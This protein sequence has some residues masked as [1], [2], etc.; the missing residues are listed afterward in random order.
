MNMS[1]NEPQVYYEATVEVPRALSD[2]VCKFII[3][4]I[5]SGLVLE[6]EEDSPVTG[7]KFYVP[8]AADRDYRARL[9]DYLGHLTGEAMPSVPPIRERTIKNV[10]WTKEYRDSIEPV[11]VADDLVVRPPWAPVPEGTRYDIVIEPKMAF[12]TGRHETT[13]TCLRIVREKLKPGSRFLDLGCG[14]GILSVLADKMGAGFIK[15]VDHD[16]VAIE[17]AHENFRI[18]QVATPCQIMFGSVD[19]CRDDRPYD[20]I[21]ANIIKSTIVVMIEKLAYLLSG[22][23]IMI[24]SGLLEPDLPE[25]SA[26]L[27]R[28][29]LSRFTIVK[30]NEWYT[31]VVYKG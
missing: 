4:N 25:I 9:N 27:N 11:L 31:Y 7:I 28:N 22:G 30:D 20:F 23:G 10:E 2:A 6:E 21:A 15:A 29:G 18:N 1:H 14:S 3:E 26:E 13:R 12:G 17:S 16:L 24:L 8:V 19:S 5:C